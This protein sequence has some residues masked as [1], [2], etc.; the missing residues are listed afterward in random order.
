MDP[1]IAC[2]EFISIARG[3]RTCDEM[4]K[5]ALVRVIE[6]TVTGASRRSDR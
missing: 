1:A 4:A 6:S 2:L 3:I 5:K